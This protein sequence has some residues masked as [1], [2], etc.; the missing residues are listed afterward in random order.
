VPDR[1]ALVGLSGVALGGLAC[2][3]LSSRERGQARDAA[4]LADA[5]MEH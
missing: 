2:T 5:S 4:A 3:W 1:W